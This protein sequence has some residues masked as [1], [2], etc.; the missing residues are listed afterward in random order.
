MRMMV[1]QSP[2]SAMPI[3]PAKPRPTPHAST[4]EAYSLDPEFFAFYRTLESYSK[5]L[6]KDA[7]LIIATDSDYFRYL[8]RITPAPSAK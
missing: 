1:G 7:T 4:I 2:N 8:R 3:A 5:S 6:G